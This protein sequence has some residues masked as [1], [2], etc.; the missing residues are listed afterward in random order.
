MT[1]PPMR[2]PEQITAKLRDRFEREWPEWARGGGTWPMRI[3]LEPP[4]TQHR[5]AD[6][7][8]CHAFADQWRSYTGPGTVAYAAARFPTG[9]HQMPKTLIL[10]A[11]T[12]AAGIDAR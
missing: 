9:T 8:A 10:A 2:T 5:S 11:P 12:A 3:G 4:S 7:V 1:G 6:P